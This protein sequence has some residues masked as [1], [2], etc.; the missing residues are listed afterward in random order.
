MELSED[1][2]QADVIGEY[3]PDVLV[4][5]FVRS[6]SFNLFHFASTLAYGFLMSDSYV[7]S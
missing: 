1:G 6:S 2:Y 5:E 7:H 4:G 3:T